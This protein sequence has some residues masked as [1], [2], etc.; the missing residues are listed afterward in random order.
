[1]IQNLHPYDIL[2]LGGVTRWHTLRTSRPQT[3]A[4]HKARVALLGVWLAHRLPVG[5]FGALDELELLRAALLHDV[6]ETQLGDMP[7]PAKQAINDWLGETPG[8]VGAQDYDTQME[9]AFW[10][11]RGVSNPMA[12]L[13]GTVRA[14]L[15]VADV[16]EAA[17][18]YWMEGI[19]LQRP[20]SGHLPTAI[21]HEALAVV[22]R[23]LPE[24]QSQAGEV[25]LAAGVSIELIE[26]IERELAA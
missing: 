13:T 11:A 9:G 16:L 2:A 5:R 23:E 18:F 1:M 15:R 24:L 22:A 4:E 21:V 10:G 26:A 20:G 12:A 7:N 8:E 19:T 17:A 14:L 25:L 3:L 6:P